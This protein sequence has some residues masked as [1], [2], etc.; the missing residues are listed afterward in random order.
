MCNLFNFKW[1]PNCLQNVGKIKE[2]EVR[3]IKMWFVAI[4]I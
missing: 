3:D 4:N 2:R 1:E